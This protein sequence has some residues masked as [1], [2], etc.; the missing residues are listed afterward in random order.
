[1]EETGSWDNKENDHN[2]TEMLDYEIGNIN[3]D[4]A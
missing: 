3:K 1:M 2:V 4:G